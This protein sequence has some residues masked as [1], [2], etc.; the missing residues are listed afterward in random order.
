[1]TEKKPDLKKILVWRSPFVIYFT[2]YI[3]IWVRRPS[4][5]E[6]I[7]VSAL[8]NVLGISVNQYISYSFFPNIWSTIIID[9]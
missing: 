2:L 9:S 7:R 3:E 1:M 6:F 8:Q 4:L 5:L